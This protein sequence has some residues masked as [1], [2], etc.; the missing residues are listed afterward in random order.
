VERFKKGEHN[1]TPSFLQ[2]LQKLMQ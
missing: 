1:W 2:A